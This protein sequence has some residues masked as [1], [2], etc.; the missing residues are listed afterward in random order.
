MHDSVS[1]GNASREG[2]DMITSRGRL[3]TLRLFSLFV[4]ICLNG[5][6]VNAQQDPC[7]VI[8]DN[9]SGESQDSDDVQIFATLAP[10]IVAGGGDVLGV[11]LPVVN[12]EKEVAS[13]VRITAIKLH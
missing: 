1:C 3:A 8:R 12:C 9:N 13:R 6:F 10:S 5:V 2:L 7:K 11:T 4:L